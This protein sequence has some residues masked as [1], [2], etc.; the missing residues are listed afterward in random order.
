MVN[1]VET[2]NIDVYPLKEEKKS[3]FAFQLERVLINFIGLLISSLI[4]SLFGIAIG[5]T[6]GGN[7]G[8]LIGFI[9]GLI[10]AVCFSFAMLSNKNLH[11]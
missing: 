7:N 3:N 4:F 8:A 9:I 2:H 10:L 6:L 5:A 1:D 11:S